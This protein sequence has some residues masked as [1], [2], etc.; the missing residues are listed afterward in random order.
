ME[1]QCTELAVV[2]QSEIPCFTK[3]FMRTCQWNYGNVIM[4]AFLLYIYWRDKPY[5]G[6]RSS[7]FKHFVQQFFYLYDWWKE[8]IVWL[9]WLGIYCRVQ[10]NIKPSSCGQ[11]FCK[12]F[13]ILWVKNNKIL[14]TYGVVYNPK[15]CKPVARTKLT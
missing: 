6:W 5:M 10:T 12:P 14:R 2:L 9:S 4:I 1:K 8:V 3:S 13:L 7:F 15:M 11:I